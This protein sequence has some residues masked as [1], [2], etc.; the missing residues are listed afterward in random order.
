MLGRKEEPRRKEEVFKKEEVK[1]D[2][3]ESI[4]GKG[5]KVEGNMHIP[6]SLRVEGRVE[7]EIKAGGD[8]FIGEEGLVVAN[9]QARNVIIAGEVQG[10]VDAVEKLEIVPTGKLFGDIK[11]AKLIIEDGATFK[12]RS[13]ARKGAEKTPTDQKKPEQEKPK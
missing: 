7:G 9:I 3:V 4:I 10:N 2:K 1:R 11:I 8:V 12:G 6:G 5:T 13:E